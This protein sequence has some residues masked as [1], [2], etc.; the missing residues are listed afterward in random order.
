MCVCV[1]CVCEC[2]YLQDE[3]FGHG[4]GPS[5]GFSDVFTKHGSFSMELKVCKVHSHT[6]RRRSAVQ[7]NLNSDSPSEETLM[8][9]FDESEFR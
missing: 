1:V 5:A 4:E 7:L 8:A 2:L 9:S 3:Q 6:A